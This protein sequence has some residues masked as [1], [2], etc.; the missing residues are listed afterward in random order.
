MWMEYRVTTST[1]ART[2]TVQRPSPQTAIWL[3]GGFD[4][5]VL[6]HALCREKPEHIDVYTV[7]RANAERFVKSAIQSVES[8]HVPICL[9]E[10]EALAGDAAY[11][12]N[13]PM[14]ALL[15]AGHVTTI[16]TGV[17]SNPAELPNGPRRP[18]VMEAHYE[19]PFLHCDKSHVV[20]LADQLGILDEVAL[21]SHSCTERLHPNDRCGECWQCR[22]RAWAFAVNELDDARELL[23]QQR[24]R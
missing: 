1:G 10:I 13:A 7:V 14:N 9:N 5:T 18:R 19:L 15:Q 21:S 8:Y 22:E 24:V 4:S 16:V 2:I 20:A 17:T 3:S 12:I 11:Q 6:L 23:I